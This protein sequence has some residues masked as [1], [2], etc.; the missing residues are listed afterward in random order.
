MSIIKKI[1]ENNLEEFVSIFN[2]AYPAFS[3]NTKEE[4]E[5]TLNWLQKTQKEYSSVNIYGLYREDKLLGGM[6]LYDYNMNMLGQTI[7]A[8]GVGM[9]AVDLLHKKEKVAKEMI[10]FF[11]KHYLNK[12][13]NITVLYPFRPDFYKKMGFGFGSKISQYKIKPINLP[14]GYSKEHIEFLT[15]DDKDEIMKCYN[16]VYENTHGMIKLSERELEPI[17][18]NSKVR[19]IG[20]KKDTK[21]YGYLIFTFKQVDNNNFLNNDIMINKL[22]YSNRDALQELLTFLYTQLDQIRYIVINTQDEN[23]HHLL[24]DPRNNSKNLIP[25]VYHESN[26]QGVGLMYRVINVTGIFNDLKKYNFNNKTI[27][28]MLKINDNLIEANNKGFIIYFNNGVANILDKG[29]YEAK[30]SLDISDF[31]SLIMGVVNFK[32]LYNYNLAEISD[33]R[34]LAVVNDLF[35][36]EQKPVCITDF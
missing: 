23:F 36:T 15:K 31:S 34:Y 1:E 7:K 14:N 19:I 4:N 6:A 28:L 24:F 3:K 18:K 5:R 27:K 35:K 29:E 8:G 25:S 11:F 2:N 9:I 21:I 33:E 32:T 16:S 26:T 30:I 20:Y 22:V 12:D 13:T 17:F 10:D